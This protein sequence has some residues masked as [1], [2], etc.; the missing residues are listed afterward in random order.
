MQNYLINVLLGMTH[1]P[2][3]VLTAYVATHFYINLFMAER[4]IPL[5]KRNKIALFLSL[6][7]FL[8]MTFFAATRTSITYKNETFDRSKNIEQIEKNRQRPV[9]REIVDKSLQLKHTSEE[10]KQNFDKITDYKKIQQE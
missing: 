6:I 2:I 7:V 8:I 1:I 9:G 5:K 10:R 4:K 3:Y